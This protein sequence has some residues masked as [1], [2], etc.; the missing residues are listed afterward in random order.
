[1][2]EPSKSDIALVIAD[3]GSGG[4]QRV[5]TTLANEW[6]LRGLKITLISLSEPETDFFT[7]AP[8]ISRLSVG[9]TGSSRSIVHSVLAN[10]QRLT[11]L[12]RLVRETGAPTVISFVGTM[13]ILVIIATRGLGLNVIISERNDPTRQHLPPFWQILRRLT[14]GLADTV[15]ANSQV[16]LIYLEKYVSRHKLAFVPNPVTH[17]PTDTD[18]LPRQPIILMVA[19]FNRQKAHDIMLEAFSLISKEVPDWQL[20]LIGTGEL[21]Q[22]LRQQAEQLGISSRVV[23]TGQVSDTFAHYRRASIFALPSRYEGTP[24]ALMEAMSTGLPSITTDTSPGA[25]V[26]VDDGVTG[27]VI[28]SEDPRALADALR[29]LIDNQE[30]RDR[31][32]EAGSKRL[33]EFKLENVM[34]IWN[35]FLP[36]TSSANRQSDQV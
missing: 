29:K 4:A 1:M 10:I 15:T 5:L 23:W 17:A 32:G 27:L 35:S 19:R 9:G 33:S 3:L 7:L 25:L 12:R 6:C 2:S 34:E 21:E 30:L 8:G 24:N 36:T 22:D 14:Y 13:N 11:R 28:P 31:L 16:A 26:F 18:E 20:E